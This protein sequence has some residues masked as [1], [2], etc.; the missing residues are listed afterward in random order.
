M[1]KQRLRQIEAV[2]E[3][4]Q[5]RAYLRACAVRIGHFLFGYRDYL[6]P[7]ALLL[8][9]ITTKPTL[10]WGSERLDEWVDACGIIVA[11]FGQG[12]RV[13]AV[14]SVENIR[15]G[16]QQKRVAAGMLIQNGLYA[17]TR[18]PLYLGNLLIMT[19]L[20]LI[21][22]AP[23]W[24]LLALPGF[25]SVY[26]AIVLAEENLLH[27]QFGRVY[28]DYCRRVPRF[29]PTLHG[30]RR[31]LTAEAFGWRR[32]FR[33]EMRIAYAWISVVLGLFIWERWEQFGYAARAAEIQI[34]GFV[35]FLGFVGFISVLW[36]QKNK[37]RHP[38]I[39]TWGGEKRPLPLSG[40]S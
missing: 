15:R 2:A 33:K 20:A 1:A 7:L 24:H 25:I 8:L 36:V 13:L 3:C 34:L 28:G 37:R 39:P 18:N 4:G 17:H 29:L 12:C 23:A 9:A 26:W 35:L 5:T 27:R 38:R 40:A 32:A 11:L 10:F 22:N 16:G 19:G 21:V 6:F 14:G 30:L 31:S